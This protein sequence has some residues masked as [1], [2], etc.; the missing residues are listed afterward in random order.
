MQIVVTSLH[1]A[2][3]LSLND[4]DMPACMS[5]DVR[6]GLL[7]RD[8]SETW[9]TAIF[10]VAASIPATVV[11]NTLAAL[12]MD[13][14]KRKRS[15]VITINRVKVDLEHGELVRVIKETIHIENDI[16]AK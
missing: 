1:P 13:R 12:L 4:V 7:R 15:T 14:L 5:V 11:A 8:V 16:D 10:T 6:P 9:A 2:A 3:I